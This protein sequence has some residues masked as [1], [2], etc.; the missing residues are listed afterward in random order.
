MN[1]QDYTLPPRMAS[2]YKAYLELFSHAYKDPE[3]MVNLFGMMMR[4]TASREVRS[5][6]WEH[7]F[8]SCDESAVQQVVRIDAP[9]K[10]PLWNISY[11]G[12]IPVSIHPQNSR[13]HNL[14]KLF[15]RCQREW[16]WKKIK[17][18][19]HRAAYRRKKRGLA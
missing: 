3:M 19:Q 6:V 4:P 18:R 15:A 7:T 14:D 10:E 2:R 5:G 11:Q 17:R 1:E 9:D 16:R 8:G 12:S 13:T